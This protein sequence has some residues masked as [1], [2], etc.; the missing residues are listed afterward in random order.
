[1][2]VTNPKKVKYMNFPNVWDMVEKM[3]KENEM[4]GIDWKH[5]FWTNV[6][7][8][9]VLNETACKGRCEIRFFNEL[10]NYD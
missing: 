5:Y 1:M 6:K 4:Y 10:P 8:S 9:I 3:G 2:W 7:E